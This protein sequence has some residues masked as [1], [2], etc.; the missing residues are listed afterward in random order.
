MHS[1]TSLIE[2]TLVVVAALAGGLGFSRLK[3][4]PILGYI[5]AGIF[6]GPSG[7]GL[8]VSREPVNML[9]EL[10]VLLLLFVI[11]MELNLRVFKK[12]WVITTLCTVLQI[13]ASLFITSIISPLFGWSTGTVLLF[14]FVMALSSTAV[15]VKVLESIGELRTETGQIAIGVLIAQDLAIVPMIL[16]LRN[17]GR[18]F[19]D[20]GMLM[21]LLF[22]VGLIVLLIGYLSRRQRVRLPLTHVIA[23]EKDLTPLVSLTVCFA[24]AAVSGLIGLSTAYGAFLA[25]LILG[26]THERILMI[27]TTKPIQSTLMMVFFLSIGLLLDLQFIWFNLFKVTLLLLVITVGKTALNIG[28]LHLL[29]LPWSQSFLIGVVLAQLGEFAFLLTTV[30]QDI[31]I[32]DKHDQKLIIALTV[33]SLT[34]SPFWL[35]AARRL[36]ARADL[37]NIGLLGILHMIFSY[38]SGFFRHSKIQGFLSR[39]TPKRSPENNDNHP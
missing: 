17:Q 7:I 28:I 30:G 5:L 2:I 27:E 38:R 9:A 31:G 15:V 37:Q 11:G 24:A 16:I 25:G 20:P 3:Q 8:V 35:A 18:S 13:G 39:L 10:G 6:L 4:P 23:G 26:N 33:L 22:S 12:A 29:R 21:K 14:G 1:E 34:F 32:I 36:K 19:F